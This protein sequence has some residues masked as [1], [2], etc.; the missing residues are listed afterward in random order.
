MKALDLKLA[1]DLWR[2]RGQALAI[3]LVLA[4]ATAT[5]VLSVGVHGSL[6]A[7]RDAYY[8]RSHF[9]DVFATLKRAPRSIVARI[10]DI[11]GVQRAEGNII[12]YATLDFPGREEPIRALINSVDEFGRSR[13]N[14]ITLRKGILPRPEHASD[15][16]VD[17][18]FAKANGL[19]LGSTVAA[20]IYG[21]RQ[22]LVIVGIGMAPNY[23]Y[24]LAPG[25][26]VPDERRF[27][28]FWMGRKAL[29]AAT[30]RR[31]AIN[32]LSLTLDRGASQAEV[33]RKV[34]S[35][36]APY[37]GTGAYGREDHLSN[38]FL[39]SE[40]KQLSAM[41]RIIPPIFLLVSTFL[42]YIVLGRM[43][44]TE[45]EQIGL[46]KAF[47]YSGWAIGW[48]YLKF[49]LAVALLAI[50][51]GSLAGIW[52]GQAMTRLYAE[53]YR[54]PF[55]TYRLSPPVFLAAGALAIGAAAL[56]ALGGVRSAMALQPAVAMSPPP[57]PVYR[58]GTVE[59][60]GQLAGFSALG[61]MIVRHVARWP[62]RSAITVLGVGLSMGLLFATM[63]FVDAS[64]AMLDQF[65]ARSQHQDL[66]VT[67]T[68]ARNEHAIHALAQIPGVLRVEASRTIPVMLRLGARSKRTAI[69]SADPASQLTARI[70]GT[71]QEVALPPA[72][73][74]LSR[75]LADQLRAKIGDPIEV[76]LLGG[77]RTRSVQQL[78]RIVDEV[79]G[80][81]A[82]AGQGTL[83]RIARDAAPADAVLLRID[84]QARTRILT[85]LKDMPVVLGVTER[86]AAL[87]KFTEV[88]DSNILTMISFYI[89]FAAA[90][91]VGVVYNSARILFSERA[92]ELATLRVLGY[93]NS[94]VAIV[95]LGEIALLV[96]L[97]LPLGCMLGYAMAQLM[98]A[99]FSSDLFRLPYAA[100][101]ASYGFAAVVV[102]SAALATALL[103][104][105]RVM[106]LDMVRVLKARE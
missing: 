2:M 48:H 40:L 51:L 98:I 84:P 76:E 95:L 88:I 8:A 77:R 57:P 19:G 45:R 22:T 68:E 58:A 12:Q 24:A 81:R 28:I 41:T 71:G 49:A 90:I 18:N 100:T 97:A 7:T 5:F 50:V 36:L 94:E 66:T 20:Q 13:L 65:F 79:V 55:L 101:R 14:A 80:A 105:R 99:M 60:L 25:D 89:A 52:M 61:H 59:R 23:V 70:D 62:G 42:V 30:D 26:L 91:A 75:Q 34:D 53:Y 87:E 56:G 64:K 73:L 38:A 39:D 93:L 102:L 69:E 3:A 104:A 46:I 83:E 47:G 1:R 82:Y 37:G 29:E 72:G 11:P 17:E 92:H 43:I 32:T 16:V 21:R 74:M 78:V 6:V 67:F 31:E 103:V 86:Q 96:V 63:Q 33:I 54:F 44:R 35:I 15:V 9:A 4:A 106:K 85:R 10:A 27:G